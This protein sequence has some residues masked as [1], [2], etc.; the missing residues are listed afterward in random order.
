M[1]MLFLLYICYFLLFYLTK[2]YFSVNKYYYSY[3]EILLLEYDA[4]KFRRNKAANIIHSF[5]LDWFV[6]SPSQILLGTRERR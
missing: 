4:S 6:R 2:G 5:S 3:L 1:F